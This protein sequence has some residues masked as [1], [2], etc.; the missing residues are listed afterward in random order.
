MVF[1]RKNSMKKSE[2]SIKIIAQNKKAYHNYEIYDK[3][4]AGMELHGSEVKS[5][6]MGQVNL[7]D[8]YC[9]IRDGELYMLNL[10]IAQ[11]VHGGY[12]NHNPTRKRRLLLHKQ[13]LAK[14]GTKLILRGYTLIPLSLYFK[15]GFAKIQLGLA[16]GKKRYDKRADLK[17]Q[18]MRRD[19]KRYE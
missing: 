17:E 15:R 8:S 10:N 5:L 1:M 16:R 13:E 12:A 14:I 4:E 9:K 7:A 2:G 6:R 11:Y 18:E 19:I 3:Y